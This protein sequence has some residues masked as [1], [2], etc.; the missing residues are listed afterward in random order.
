MNRHESFPFFSGFPFFLPREG[1][2]SRSMQIRWVLLYGGWGVGCVCEAIDHLII[3]WEFHCFSSSRFTAPDGWKS[4]FRQPNLRNFSGEDPRTPLRTRGEKTPPDPPT[5]F[6]GFSR[7]SHSHACSWHIFECVT[8]SKVRHVWRRP[9]RTHAWQTWHIWM[10][11][12]SENKTCMKASQVFER[13]TKCS[14]K[15]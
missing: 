1:P 12:T 10:R 9:R 14:N 15:W 2:F 7:F 6:S 3:T 8:C 4:R 5:A 13:A 11:D